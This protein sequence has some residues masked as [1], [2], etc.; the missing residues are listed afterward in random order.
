VTGN[1]VLMNHVCVG[2]ITAPTLPTISLLS[3]VHDQTHKLMV[4]VVNCSVPGPRVF[5]ARKGQDRVDDD[6]VYNGTT[7]RSPTHADFEEIFLPH[8][9]TGFMKR[10]VL[11]S[12]QYAIRL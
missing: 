2:K 4:K 5:T 12:D 1:G 11:T 9:G 10:W 6:I 8:H 7:G 3:R